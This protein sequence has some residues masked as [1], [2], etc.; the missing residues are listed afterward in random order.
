M[1]QER[2]GSR[3]IAT[4]VVDV[5][6]LGCELRVFAPVDVDQTGR[7]GYEIRERTAWMPVRVRSVRRGARGWTVACAF[8]RPTPE[9]Q[10]SIYAFMAEC[11]NG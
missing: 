2:N 6:V 5:T 10:R 8:D 11:H 7:L 3:T 9:Q 1:L 4:E